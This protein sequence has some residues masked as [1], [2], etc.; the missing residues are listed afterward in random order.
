[1]RIS[2]RNIGKLAL[3]EAFAV[4][5]GSMLLAISQD[6]KDRFGHLVIAA[7]SALVAAVA[8]YLCILQ[9]SLPAPQNP[10]ESGQL[11]EAWRIAKGLPLTHAGIMYGPLSD[12][13]IAAVFKLTGPWLY[14]GRIM[15]AIATLLT[16]SIVTR[17]VSG[18]FTT[19]CL[20]FGISLRTINYFVETR[21][22]MIA[23][24]FAVIAVICFYRD[25]RWFFWGLVALI[26]GM[27]FKQTG[28]AAALVPLVTVLFG[29]RPK[30]SRIILPLVTVAVTM[31]LW[32]L[33]LPLSY[34][35]AVTSVTQFS[36]PINTLA[37]NTLVL[38][39]TLPLFW[40]CFAR[41]LEREWDKMTIWLLAATLL[42]CVTGLVTESKIGGT[43]NSLLPF[44]F[45]AIAFCGRE[46]RQERWPWTGLAA[47]LAVVSLTAHIGSAVRTASMTFGDA[48]YPKI[49]AAARALPGLVTCPDD[50]FLI[51]LAKGDPRLSNNL[52]FDASGQYAQAPKSVLSEIDASDYVVE[53]PSG[54]ANKHSLAPRNFQPVGNFGGYVIWRKLK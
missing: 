37:S 39:S 29:Q 5:V 33:A 31:S 12:G 26:L 40:V 52:E 44:F 51:V 11:T 54:F 48:N 2:N 30:L 15:S 14:T 13:F 23:L 46:L 47:I 9:M 18:G 21:P 35:Y 7:A 4:K 36:I 41:C 28:A 45:A 10:W 50:P 25:G 27:L 49:V 1:V 53:V 3:G 16:V 42:T 6:T 22:D 34:S 43:Y 24:L 20:L 17:A 19:W 8:C 38:L 32:R